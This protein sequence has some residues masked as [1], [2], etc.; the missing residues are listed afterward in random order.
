MAQ[1]SIIV[2]VYNGERYLKEALDSIQAQTMTDFE[3]IIVNDCSTDSSLAIAEDYAQKDARFTVISNE[4]N[5]KLPFSLN[6]GH[7]AAT[8]NLLTW[9]SDDNILFPTFLEAHLSY[10]SDKN[11]DITYAPYLSIDENGEPLKRTYESLPPYSPLKYIVFENKEYILR[12]VLPPEYLANDNC[13]GASFMYRKDVF[14]KINGY[15]VNKFLYED[16]DFWIRAYQSRKNFKQIQDI[17]YK[18]RSHPNSLS[19]QKF[20][21][22]YYNFR[23][24]IK[25]VI[26]TQNKDLAFEIRMTLLRDICPH[27]SLR[28]YIIV[29]W[30][31][32]L[33]NSRKLIKLT[34]NK[35]YKLLKI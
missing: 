8:S 25:E 4:H 5:S 16:Y 13:I 34:I 12:D 31:S 21:D 7:K 20:P 17:V 32:F 22:H 10:F 30:E 24:S 1:V 6:V 27:L 35:T 3:C 11:I 2:P 23:Y 18:Y 29:L 28:R 19:K 33:I 15:D 26:P 14:E 9:T